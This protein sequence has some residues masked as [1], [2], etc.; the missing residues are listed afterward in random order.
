MHPRYAAIFDIEN[1]ELN[2]H[3]CSQANDQADTLSQSTIARSLTLNEQL[4]ADIKLSGGAI[5]IN[6]VV[7]GS[8][9]QL[10]DNQLTLPTPQL[11]ASEKRALW[12]LMSEHLDKL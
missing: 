2:Q 10:N 6:S 7:Q 3:Y 12:A 11:N 8:E 5:I 4:F 9:M 1:L